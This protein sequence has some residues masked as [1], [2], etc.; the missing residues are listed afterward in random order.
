V[1]PCV[2]PGNHSIKS[3]V[4]WQTSERFGWPVLAPY[5]NVIALVLTV[6][7]CGCLGLLVLQAIRQRQT[8]LN[9]ML[10]LACTVF[11]L[12]I[13]SDSHDYT[14]SFLVAPVALLFAQ[15]DVWNTARSPRR[16]LAQLGLLLLFA[17]AYGFTLFS[18]AYKHD[19]VKN[20]CL[21]LIVML[22]TATAWSFLTES[23]ALVTPPPTEATSEAPARPTNLRAVP[24]PLP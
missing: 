4:A 2:W 10:M 19:W 8:V 20:N 9:P 3:F 24:E 5:A 21:P 13:P 18:F 16:R 12:T 11:A 22:I 17:C 23:K 1:E 14:L 7:V 15:P 6:I